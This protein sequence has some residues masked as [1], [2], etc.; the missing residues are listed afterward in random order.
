MVGGGAGSAGGRSGSAGQTGIVAVGAYVAAV[1]LAARTL[2]HA[3]VQCPRR[4]A[5]ATQTI[6]IQRPI[7]GKTSN[8]AELTQSHSIVKVPQPARTS[9]SSRIVVPHEGILARQTVGV[10][11]RAGLAGVVASLAQLRVGRIVVPTG[12]ADAGKTA[13]NFAV[14]GGVATETAVGPG[15]VA[16]ACGTCVVA[17]QTSS[18][19]VVVEPVHARTGIHVQHSILAALAR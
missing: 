11:A 18:R 16:S 15:S 12:R 14:H 7:A 9:I 10:A 1:E 19:V 8:V 5:L 4:P 6:V 17:G 13:G 3:S 2:T